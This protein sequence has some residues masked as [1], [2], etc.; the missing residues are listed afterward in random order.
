MTNATDSA[1]PIV[2][3]AASLTEQLESA[4]VDGHVSRNLE[5]GTFIVSA[6]ILDVTVYRD[7]WRPCGIVD[8]L[9]YAK[10]AVDQ[11]VR[12]A[13]PYVASTRLSQI[14]KVLRTL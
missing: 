1:A 12:M 3:T 8:A 5:T 2:T 6:S 10:H 13:D 7:T 11:A 4:G 9:C 14:E